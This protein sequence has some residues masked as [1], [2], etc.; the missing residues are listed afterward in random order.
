VIGK[1]YEAWD[2]LGYFACGLALCV[3][4]I[5]IPILFPGEA[6]KKLPW[7]N[8]FATKA[9][10]FIAIMNF[11]GNYFWSHYFFVL[12]GAAYSFPVTWKLN[13]IPIMLFMITQSY[14]TTYYLISN[15]L[16][17]QLYQ[18][19]I[20]GFKRHVIVFLAVCAL[21]WFFAFMETWTIESVPYYSFKDKAQMYKIGLTFYALY[22]VP[23]FPMFF[24]IDEENHSYWKFTEAATS[25]LAAS[26]LAFYLVDFWRLLVGNINDTVPGGSTLPFV[27]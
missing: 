23:S 18:R 25:G 2:D 11:T 5:L 20:P 14:F 1:Y 13:E 19:T 4:N 9:N 21:S 15:F 12:L 3:P 24:W 26:M 27:K 8:R 6:D 17:R 7:Y 10:V 16:M 22:F